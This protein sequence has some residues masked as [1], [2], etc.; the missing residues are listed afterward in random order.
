MYGMVMFAR[1]N[2]N[3]SHERTD[4][5]YAVPKRKVFSWRQNDVSVSKWPRNNAGKE[6]D[7]L[8]YRRSNH[9]KAADTIYAL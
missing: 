3:N 5:T 7:V 1:S 6:F 2:S 8:V 9:S 4:E